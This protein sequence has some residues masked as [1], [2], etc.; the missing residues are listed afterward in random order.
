MGAG[1]TD[2]AAY[3]VLPA[4]LMLTGYV[5]ARVG[6]F[7][8]T[9][10]TPD[11]LVVPEYFVPLM[12]NVMACREIA[13]PLAVLSVALRVIRA[14]R[15]AVAGTFAASVVGTRT[16]NVRVLRPVPAAVV[17]LIVPDVAPTGTVALTLVEE[18]TVKVGAAVP[19]NATAVAPVKPVPLMVTKVPAPPEVGLRPVT[20]GTGSV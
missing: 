19:L 11:V 9:E 13:V 14:P 5:P 7:P 20:V 3:V 2:E 4:N 16:V 1:V 8:R 6:A 17:T 12:M 10:T 15:A 18:A